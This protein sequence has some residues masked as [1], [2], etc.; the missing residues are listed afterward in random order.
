MIYCFSGNG[1][2]RYVARLLS[3]RLCDEA[4]M[5]DRDMI[6][7]VMEMRDERQASTGERVIWVF[8][9]YAWGLPKPVLVATKGCV[10]PGSRHYMVATCGDDCGCAD[11]LWRAAIRSNGGIPVSAFTVEM[12]NTYT[13]LPG[14]DVDSPDVVARKLAAV[15]K[16]VDEVASLIAGGDEVTDV[17]RGSFP[18]FKT[19]VIYPRFMKYGVKPHKFNYDTARCIGCGSCATVCPMG[20]V[21]MR[22]GHP[23]WGDLCAMCLACYHTCRVH[24]VNYGTATRSKGQYR[25]SDNL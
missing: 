6:D 15:P 16:R 5:I 14:F 25:L 12:P 20:N 13:L 7:R 11:D 3:E 21:E 2:S 24:A 8:P 10:T 22:D 4:V 18:R 23:V 9:I 19:D 17:V 1:N